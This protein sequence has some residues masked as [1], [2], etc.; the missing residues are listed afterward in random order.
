MCGRGIADPASHRVGQRYFCDYHIERAHRS[1]GFRW[2]RSGLAEVL[3][4]FVFLGVVALIWGWGEGT[5]LPTSMLMGTVLSL[6]PAVVW[7]VYIYRQDHIEPEPWSLVLGVFLLGGI[8][9]Y[10]L[11]A[12]IAQ[13]WFQIQQWQHRAAWSPWMAAICV[14]ATLQQLCT[15]LVVRYTVYLTDEFDEPLDGVVYAT[16]AALGIATVTNVDFVIRHHGILPVAG[17]AH[18]ILNS[19]VHVAAAAVLGYGLGRSRFAKHHGQ[20]KLAMAFLFSILINGG[21]KRTALFTGAQG[22]TFRPW[23]VLAVAALVTAC[24]L[25]GIDWLS[26]RLRR[27][28]LS[29]EETEV[30]HV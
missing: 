23:I 12:P 1:P 6:I 9:G 2:S 29:L 3:L 7:M 11:A 16:A 30:A 17:A 28:R 20:L 13:D 19:L 25:L 4:M 27:E 15:Y 26:A 21:L 5:V 14:E 24:V 8:F 22:G 10:A 18:I